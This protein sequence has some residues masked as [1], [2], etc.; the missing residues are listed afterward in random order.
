MKLFRNT[1]LGPKISESLSSVLPV[2]GIVLL[3]MMT[4]VP[5]E[6]A[7]M[8]SFLFGAIF[9]ILGMG[10]FT[11][12]AE[13]AMTPIGEYVGSRMTKSKNLLVIIFRGNDDNGI[14]TRSSGA[15]RTALL[16]PLTSYH[17]VGSR[18]SWTSLGSGNAENTL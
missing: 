7:M 10:L 2:S 17:L 11:L 18:R 16:D 5:V 14:R 8:L 1:I 12:G 13:A 15:R 6:P 9:L 3:L 4:I